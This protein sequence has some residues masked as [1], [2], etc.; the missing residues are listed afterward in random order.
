MDGWTSII[1]YAPFI[2]CEHLGHSYIFFEFGKLEMAGIQHRNA[3][4]QMSGLY[5]KHP[6]GHMKVL[7][8][9][10]RGIHEKRKETIHRSVSSFH[11][12]HPRPLL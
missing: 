1:Q 10:V 12:H 6:C 2:P 11:Y 5:Y 4:S 3:M 8:Q 9:I 7:V